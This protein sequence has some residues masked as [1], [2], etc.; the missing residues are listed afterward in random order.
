MTENTY[1]GEISVT[2]AFDLLRENREAVLIDVRTAPEWEFVGR[3]ELS[4]AG[5]TP[6]LLEWQSWPGGQPNPR[7]VDQVGEAG[8]PKDAPILLLCRSGVRSKAAAIALTSA[9]YGQC[10][11]VT[12]GFEGPKD[13]GGHRGTAAGWKAAGLPWVQG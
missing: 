11:N 3:P 5:K 2:Q 7:F 4:E 8:V 12:D 13:A 1:A 9:G 6:L 10:Y